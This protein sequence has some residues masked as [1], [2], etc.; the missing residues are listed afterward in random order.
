MKNVSYEQTGRRELIRRGLACGALV[1]L[2]PSSVVLA[3][4]G[5]SQSTSSAKLP[6]SSVGFSTAGLKRIDDAMN[7]MV[8]RGET[9]GMAGIVYRRG[10]LAHVTT[11]GWQDIDA[12]KP[13]QRDTIFQIMSMTK[14]ITA[15]AVLILVDDGRL[16]LYA[17]VEKYLP[18]FANGRVLKT[19]SSPLDDTVPAERPMRIVDL[20]TYRS[21]LASG[22][23]SSTPT[24]PLDSAVAQIYKT[25]E[26]DPAS[27]LKAIAALPLGTQ[28]GITWSY[29]TASEVLSI[30]ISR[31]SGVPFTDFLQRRI[32]APL[33]MKDTAH[34]VPS[35]KRGRLATVYERSAGT[36]EMKVSAAYNSFPDAPPAFPLGAYGLAS[37][38]DDYLQFARMLLGQGKK[39]NVR[40]LSHRAVGLMTTNHLTV[41]QR[42]AV[43]MSVAAIF[44]GQGWGLGLSIVVDVPQQDES[45]AFSSLGAFGW[46]GAFGTWWQ[47]DPKE[48]MIQIYMHQFMTGTAWDLSRLTFQKLGYD[49]L[50]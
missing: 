46:P 44:R 40:I 32:F 6:E 17:P 25:Y 21:G 43:P 1:S 37:T 9:P 18:E 38:L 11:A 34:F 23:M 14:P 36:R 15:A 42:A 7:R 5:G 20:L 24:F 16:D 19:P 35:E 2:V 29:G 49:A 28:P 13:M 41:E 47:V 31:V 45:F 3:A 30:L 48:N 22:P 39:D 33:G 12:K 26:N 8:E 10:A 27:W 4:L 50:A